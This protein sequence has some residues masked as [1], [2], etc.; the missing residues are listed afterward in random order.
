M[1]LVKLTAIVVLGLVL[2][3][4]FGSLNRLA[5]SVVITAS[6]TTEGNAP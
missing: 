1:T 6:A 2:G 5:Q 4:G 3:A